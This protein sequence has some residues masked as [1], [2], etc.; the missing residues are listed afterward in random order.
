MPPLDFAPSQRGIPLAQ[1]LRDGEFSRLMG[2]EAVWAFEREWTEE[3][4][5]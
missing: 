4:P 1:R 5:T 2:F 3:R